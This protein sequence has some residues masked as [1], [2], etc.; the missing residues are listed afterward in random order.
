MFLITL[1]TSINVIYYRR[2]MVNVLIT[3]Y[4][5]SLLLYPQSSVDCMDSIITNFFFTFF[6]LIIT[7]NYF[8]I[9]FCSLNQTEVKC[10]K[11]REK[12]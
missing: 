2:K 4:Y 5:K 9:A 12:L 1:V 7:N 3:V 8:L 6:T 11:K 10:M